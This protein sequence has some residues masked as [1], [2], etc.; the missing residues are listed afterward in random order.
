MTSKFD[1]MDTRFVDLAAH[2]GCSRK[3]APGRLFR[4]LGEL[5]VPWADEPLSSMVPRDYGVFSVDGTTCVMNADILLPLANDPADFGEIVVAHVLSDI[6]C[7]GA[8]PLCAFNLLCVPEAADGMDGEVVRMMDAATARLRAAG[9]ILLG[10]H[11]M[12][13]QGEFSY[14][15][16]A[17]GIASKDRIIGN[18][19][20][21]PGDVLVLTKPL[22]TSIATKL[23]KMEVLL[24]DQFEDVL[25]GMKSLNDVAAHHMLL[26]GANACTDITGFGFLGHTKNLLQAS[27]VGAVISLGSLPVYESVRPY[28]SSSGSETRL[29]DENVL[30]ARSAIHPDSHSWDEYRNILFDAQVSGG[31][32]VSLP[33]EAAEH[34]VEALAVKGVIAHKIGRVTEEHPG[35]VR[36][37]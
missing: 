21:R 31:L 4:L 7:A 30:Y 10:G 20:A 32:L 6:Y 11:T 2:G 18:D 8:T 29:F 35:V 23:W 16:A 22:G 13:P 34:Y 27:G 28:M 37:A 33:V 24:S 17:I 5:T 36:L 3:M 14:G 25:A 15:L 12:R 19:S 26:A 1:A 9:A